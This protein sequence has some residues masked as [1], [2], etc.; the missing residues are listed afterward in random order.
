MKKTIALIMLLI[1]ISACATTN[2]NSNQKNIN[3]R[4]GS[5]G[6]AMSFVPD[7]PPAELL[8][9]SKVPVT[10]RF[11]NKG[12]YNI[13]DLDFYLSGYDASILPFSAKS[14]TG[15][16]KISGKDQ[17]NP[18]GS[19]ESYV[20]W[21]ANSINLG[22]L[23]SIDS[24]KQAIAV[25]ACYGYATIATPTLCFDPVSFETLSA[26]KCT[27]SVKDLG[28]NQ[29]A[30]IAV[31]SLTQKLSD[32]EIFLEI[33]MANVGKGTPF[34]SPLSDCM[35]LDIVNA[36]VVLLNRVAFS[37]GATFTCNPTTI[38]LTNNNGFAVCSARL[39]TTSSF[40]QTPVTIQIAYNYR[41]TLP[42]KEIT[43]INVNK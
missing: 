30:P 14:Q 11:A 33:Q 10:V 1:F 37:N 34:V 2:N 16:I 25:T 27:F 36:N 13:A 3:W 5:E 9:R 21:S 22:N 38:R 12:A 26:S 32:D 43:I 29:G 39:P 19:V 41:E 7:N 18:T 17:Y 4:T 20:Q 15:N 23:R 6:I 28:S 42:T 31:T 40:F 35:G 8:S 24:F